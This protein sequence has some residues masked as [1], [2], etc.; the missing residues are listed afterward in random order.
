VAKKSPAALQH[1][2]HLEGT[3][4]NSRLNHVRNWQ[5]MASEANWSVSKLAKK[6]N[7]SVRTLERYFLGELKQSPHAWLFEQRQRRGL[8]L[9]RK[10]QAVK[11]V[12]ASL[13]YAHGTQFSRD[14][15]RYWGHSPMSQQVS[16]DAK[17]RMGGAYC[18][19]MSQIVP[20]IGFTY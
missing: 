2:H 7:V 20:R 15:R 9:L 10:S 1:D 4:M 19:E 3:V 12:A 17:E 8:E 6:L 18:S 13:G 5:E 14:F 16:V 11:E